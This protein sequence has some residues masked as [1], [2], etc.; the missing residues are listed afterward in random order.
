MK[1]YV[2]V[3]RSCKGCEEVWVMTVGGE[4]EIVTVL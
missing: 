2:M 4:G 3:V 1:K